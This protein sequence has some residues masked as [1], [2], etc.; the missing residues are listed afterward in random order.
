MDAPAARASGEINASNSTTRLPSLD[1]LE[2][3]D[4]EEDSAKAVSRDC[5]PAQERPSRLLRVSGLDGKGVDVEI[6]SRDSV[7]MIKRRISA[8]L[9]VHKDLQDV[10]DEQA[11]EPFED[12]YE[13][14]EDT[15]ELIVINKNPDLHKVTPGPPLNCRVQ[16]HREAKVVASF[17]PDDIVKVIGDR[18]KG[19]T[20]GENHTDWVPILVEVKKQTKKDQ[21]DKKEGA[22]KEEAGEDK[23]EMEKE[24]LE[25]EEEEEQEMELVKAWCACGSAE[26]A[27][28]VG[29]TDAEH[30]EYYLRG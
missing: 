28:L 30:Q 23:M 9:G 13:L 22:E 5:A 7:G 29:L 19:G 21:K 15:T 6:H 16:A 20:Y 1:R 11:E 17:L 14:P 2:L 4:D 12:D 10:F 25:E 3:S 18:T 8:A 24:E 27:Y 26:E